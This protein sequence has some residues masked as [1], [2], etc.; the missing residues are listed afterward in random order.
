MTMTA[1]K[2]IDVEGFEVIPDVREP[3]IFLMQTIAA[4]KDPAQGLLC[5]YDTGCSA[6]GI[7]NRAYELLTTLTV[8]RGPTALDVAG[9]KS[10]IIPHGDEQFHLEMEC[11]KKK[12]TITGLRMPHIT[13]PFPVY[14]LQRA[15]EDLQKQ[16]YKAD[17]SLTLPSVDVEVGGSGVD[18][19]LGIKYLK[20]YPELVYSLPSG[21]AVY[22]AKLK[23]ASGCQAVLGGP[24]AVWSAAAEKAQHM[25][26]RAYLTAEARAW[27]VTE[28]WVEINQGK[29]S[30]LAKYITVDTDDESSGGLIEVE[31]PASGCGHCHCQEEA[32][33]AT[34]V[35]TA[36]QE[37]KD[38]WA[39]ENLGTEATYR[40]VSC[41]NCSKCRNSEIL[42][43][44]SFKEEAEQSY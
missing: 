7:S 36:A 5:F 6:A 16:A 38:F 1:A 28:S 17:K 8:R 40:C 21:L 30:D 42:E 27:Y 39:V 31:Q 41:R 12:A 9:A 18:V 13:T 2:L 37:E 14:Q 32:G 22:K 3:A 11:G 19:I 34:G 20:Y 43:A 10:V 24:H 25:N 35:Y 23:S 29:L 4:E 26:P 15:W 44:I 33:G